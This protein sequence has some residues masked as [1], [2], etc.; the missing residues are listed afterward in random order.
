MY[1]QYVMRV[2]PKVLLISVVLLTI[3]FR[4]EQY[5]VEREYTVYSTVPCDQTIHSCFVWDCDPSDSEC[6]QT[7]YSKIE[8]A[9]NRAPECIAEA[10]CEDFLCNETD[11][12]FSS[13]CSV[14]TLEEGEFCTAP[15][16]FESET[17]SI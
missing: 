16:L 17:E 7:P 13:Q 3:L 10:T 6:D 11:G 1:T 9:A 4:F 15:G 14:D 5:E 12:C 8:I 2:I